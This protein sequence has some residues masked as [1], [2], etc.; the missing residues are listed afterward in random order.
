M[1]DLLF[2]Y[3]EEVSHIC[4]GSLGT[5]SRAAQKSMQK[6]CDK[7]S[8]MSLF[9]I[10]EKAIGRF[11]LILRRWWLALAIVL[12]SGCAGAQPNGISALNPTAG[13]ND[14]VASITYRDG[15]V[16]YISQATLDQ[17]QN[18]IFIGPQGPA[19]AELVLNELIS[20]RLLLRLA[21]NND[22]TAEA[23]TIDQSMGNLRGQ[24]CLQ[25]IQQAG[26]LVNPDDPRAV[27]DACA[28]SLGFN[29]RNELRSFIAEQIT[30][31]NVVRQFAAKDLIKAS[32]ILFATEDYTRAQEIYGRLCEVV[33][34]A[35]QPEDVAR[36]NTSNFTALA[37][38]YSIEPNANQSGGSLP[39][40]NEQG[41]T[42]DGTPFD[43]TFVSNTVA[44]KQQFID[45][46][47]AISRP[48]E[49]QFG[50]H[51]VK[52]D[53]LQASEESQQIFRDGVLQL[54]RDAQPADLSDP[55]ANDGPVPLIGAAEVLISLPAPSALPT[56][57]P[58]VPEETA[59]PEA[60]STVPEEGGTATPD[61]TATATP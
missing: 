34:H 20:E 55:Q 41:L 13:P 57:E 9:E 11:L 30:I 18:Q 58:I 61:E 33:G 52:I 35:T 49:T 21:R 2:K 16:E 45:T 54:A 22:V 25:R 60:T 43:T 15:A 38:Q 12:L 14:A 3:E 36:C 7:R 48:F 1:L 29:G 51:I 4:R 56:V 32:H 6:V 10:A 5:G 27:E 59:T 8:R 40:F 53:E 42:E 44:L 39:P 17:F 19:P 28:R 47:I 23:Q 50:W 31:G 26:I 46:G 37:K 24:F